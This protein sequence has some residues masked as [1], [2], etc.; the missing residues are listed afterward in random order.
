[1]FH[2]IVSAHGSPRQIALGTAIGVWVAFTPT[3]GLQIILAVL[4]STLVGASRAAAIVPVWI[5]NPFTMIP[6]YGFTYELGRRLVGGP[7]TAAAM[8]RLRRAVSRLLTYDSWDIIDQFREMLSLGIE[9]LLPMTVGG[10]I[11]GTI[12]AAITYPLILYP[13][14][15]YQQH[16]GRAQP[17]WEPQ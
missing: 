7:G 6:I 1:M 2:A 8:L 9:L 12:A 13:I 5:T 3:Y 11:V 15:R 17:A 10:V 4:L 16:H 14:K